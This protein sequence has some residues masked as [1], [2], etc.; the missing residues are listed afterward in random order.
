MA[1][2]IDYQKRYEEA[3]QQRSD[4]LEGY[5]KVLMQYR[6]QRTKTVI[7]GVGAPWSASWPATSPG[8]FAWGAEAHIRTDNLELGGEV[9]RIIA[10]HNTRGGVGS[11]VLATHTCALGRRLGMTVA[12]LSVDSFREFEIWLEH[13]GIPRVDNPNE[14]PDVDLIVMDVKKSAAS[15]PLRPNAWLIPIDRPQSCESACELTDR[16]RGDVIWIGNAGYEVGPPPAYLGRGL[17]RARGV[18]FSR[19]LS[20]AHERQV[21][22]WDDPSLAESPGARALEM[23][24]HD[25]LIL[26]FPDEVA[27][28]VVQ[29]GD[30]FPVGP[31]QSIVLC[32]PPRPRVP[33][34]STRVALEFADAADHTADIKLEMLADG[35]PVDIA[36]DGSQESI[37]SPRDLLGHPRV[38]DRVSVKLTNTSTSAILTRA[39]VRV[40]CSTP[41]EE[42]LRWAQDWAA[43]LT[44][45]LPPRAA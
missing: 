27:L 42:E 45:Q 17:L 13:V 43:R 6:S 31:G 34:V 21:V 41:D 40:Q 20:L 33:L 26:A 24:L 23:A 5:S 18:P 1:N 11:T 32:H 8:S 44:A 15:L 12:G 16:L 7:V 14:L 39:E 19:A 38:A 10:F 22:V 36:W 3:M 37:D 9:M 29:A 2:E 25:A 28:D 35:E 30:G 4:L